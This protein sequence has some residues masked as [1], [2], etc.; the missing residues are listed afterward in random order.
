MVQLP[1]GVILTLFFGALVVGGIFGFLIS[2]FFA[3]ARIAELQTQLER[4]QRLYFNAR[5]YHD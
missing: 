3:T 1:L 2:G 5:E 4:F